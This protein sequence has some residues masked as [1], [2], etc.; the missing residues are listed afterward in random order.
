[1]RRG[2]S[3]LSS[4]IIVSQ[5]VGCGSSD[6]PAAPSN[7]GS[8]AGGPKTYPALDFADIGQPVS[9]SEKFYRS[10]GPVW[11]P[12][13]GV[14]LFTDIVASGGGTVYRL[15]PPSTI[16]VELEPD[17]NANGLALDPDGTL[18]AAGHA[19]GN[20]WRR[21]GDAM[22]TLAPCTSPDTATCFEGQPLNAPNDI[23]ARSDGTIYF[24]DPNF[25][26]E[27]EGFPPETRP[28]AGAE[29]VYRLGKDGALGREDV[30]TSG[31]N[32]I[33]LSPDEKTLYVTYTADGAVSK[34]DVATDGS[35]SNKRTFV[36]GTPVAD[37]MCVD[38]GGNVYV[39]TLAGLAVFDPAGEALGTIEFPRPAVTNCA[40][41]GS[42]QRT[43][44][45]TVYA[46]IK[47]AKDDA[48]LF[49]IDAMPVPGIA[50]R[51]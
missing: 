24:T 29:G 48:G 25:A 35:L 16:D 4:A 34:F 46:S 50:G 17:G 39:G 28:L 41:G 37:G 31:P 26:G 8:D 33:G 21:S 43:L 7:A 1:M 32:G 38:A 51:N 42:D 2:G 30:G 10:E 14:L 47:A 5:L 22:Q 27:L 11:D 23:V 19:A 20:V 40:F 45:V 9:K 13:R 15:T 18:I 6:A 12:A 49:S 44:F 36:T 3:L